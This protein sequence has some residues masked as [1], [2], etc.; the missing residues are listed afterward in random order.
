MT[1]ILAAN[2]DLTL[3]PT[4]SLHSP[5]DKNSHLRPRRG[6]TAANGS[7]LRTVFNQSKASEQL[8]TL[9]PTNE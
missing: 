1:V 4:G 3:L 8:Q 9:Q 2:T 7:V 5:R 6:Y